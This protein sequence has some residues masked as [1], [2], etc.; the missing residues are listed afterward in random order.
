M[1]DTCTETVLDQKGH[2]RKCKIKV[3]DKNSKCHIHKKAKTNIENLDLTHKHN[4][5]NLYY[6]WA[7]IDPSEI[8]FLDSEPWPIHIIIST[9]T[10]QLNNS[11]M[12][13]P[14]LIYPNNPFTREPFTESA[15]LTLSKKIKEL[16][17]K[18]HISLKLLLEQTN[19]SRFYG[20]AKSNLDRHSI[21]LMTVICKTLRFMTVNYKNSQNNYTGF[22]IRK[23]I[24]KTQF[25]TL[26]TKLNEEPYQIIYKG[27]IINNPY[28]EHLKYLLKILPAD[29]SQ[30][31][32]EQFCELL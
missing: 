24:K 22:W 28:R 10:H 13:N 19:I 15:L 31:T 32:D 4:L 11:N 9:I 25:E 1:T 20:E 23:N 5:M 8:I 12:E 27:T 3:K 14:Y 17:I 7:D 16:N 6:S 30:P 29:E 21:L 26:Y 2:K 18:V